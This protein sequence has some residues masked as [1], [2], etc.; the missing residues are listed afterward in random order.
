[1]LRMI[2]EVEPPKPSTRISSSD[3]LPSIAANR[4]L[5]PRRLTSLLTGELDWIV[6]KALEKDRGRRY[7]TANGLAM[8]IGRYLADE[9]VLASPPSAAYRMKK[10]VRRNKGP[11]AAAA[12]LLL[13][14]S[15]GVVGTTIGLVRAETAW[16][17]EAEQRKI[18]QTKEQE[19]LAEKTKALEAA[20]RERLAK[21][22]VITQK[23][24]VEAA[25]DRE[26][27]ERGYAEAIAKFVKDD[28]LA[29]TSVEGQTRFDGEQLTKDAT[30]RDLL[31]RAA[32]KLNDRKDLAPRTE[33][34]LCWI[35][36]VS[37]GGVGEFAQAM[38][39]LE[40][41]VELYGQAIGREE[42]A[43]LNSQN[44]L[45]VA[46]SAAGQYDRSI[47]LYE[48]TLKLRKV[49][50]GPEHPDTL[51]SMSNLAGAYRAAGRL[52]LA[53]PLS[54][55]ALKLIKAKLGPEHPITLASMNDLAGVYRAAGKFDQAVPLSEETLRLR[56]AKHGPEHLDTL[57]SMNNL[58]VA[59]WSTNQLDKSVPLFEDVLTRQEAKLG[60]QHHDTQLTVANLGVNFKDAGRLQEAIPLLEEAYHASHRFPNLRRI[61]APLLDAYVK[62]GN[63]SE[64]V[65]LVQELLAETRKTVPHD[66]PQLASVLAQAGLTLLTVKAWNEAEPILRECLTLRAKLAADAIPQVLPW[67]VANVRSMLGGAL[68]GQEKFA[69]AEPLL[70]A[71]YAGLKE[72]ESTIPPEA[73]IRPAE[74][75]Q[76]L[77]DFYTATGQAEKADEWRKK[78]EET[79]AAEEKPKPSSAG[80]LS[81]LPCPH[82]R[83]LFSVIRVYLD[84]LDA[85]RFVFRPGLGCSSAAST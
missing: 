59:Y 2:R 20:E 16:Q 5:E 49:K 47:Q 82:F 63:T 34:E 19:A 51:Q 48:E 33:A 81:P 62:A 32:E 37:Y 7:E 28:F 41:S 17:A 1:M 39:Y 56:K 85:G 8:D 25:R 18:A 14:L 52:D 13:A 66:S 4:K 58:A 24:E 83:R 68:S 79:K 44:S 55:E 23:S 10:F 67:Q 27:K 36:G 65:G 72:N 9:P 3:E 45:A 46:Y 6:M 12:A 64:A 29:L 84:H 43:T 70:L 73:K 57:Q 54:E 11:V 75:L 69:D 80:Q 74:A 53:L 78:L 60:R 42:D 76:R 50:L 38:S 35:I 31:D 15:A 30:L 21:E 22:E 40:R 71:G 26:A 61:G 77:L